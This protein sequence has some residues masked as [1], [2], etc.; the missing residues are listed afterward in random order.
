MPEAVGIH[1]HDRFKTGRRPPKNAP[2]LMLADILTGT[3][4]A[5]PATADHFK[6]QTF[7]LYGN[8]K[9]GDCGPVSVANLVRLVS[10]GLLGAEVQPSQADVFDLYKRSGNPTFNP[11]T[12][13]GDEG[14]DMQTMCEALLTGGIGAIKPIAFA[15]VNATDAAELESA[16]SIFG[17]CLW[18]V[19]LETAQQTQTEASPP[20]WDHKKSSEWGGHAVLNGAYESGSLEDVES[21]AIRVQTTAAFRA[22][23]LEEAWVVIF[24]WHLDHPAFQAGVDVQ[25]LAAAYQSLTGKTLP[26]P[27]PTPSPTP[28]P[29]PA[30]DGDA[31]LW[32]ALKPWTEERHVGDNHRAAMAAKAWASARGFI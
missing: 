12:G 32:A 23:Q 2:A 10:G 24:Q 30:G 16:V 29:T 27:A 21:W 5:H 17:G 3:T 15:K 31:E 22:S 18:G 9:Y 7:G 1:E 8:D 19:N 11:A 14:V 13:A 28:T 26:T 25:A 4:P 6:G 20:K